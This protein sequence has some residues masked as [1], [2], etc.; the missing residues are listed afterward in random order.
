VWGATAL[1][2]LVADWLK[3]RRFNLLLLGSFAVVALLL[4]G[5]GIYGLISFSVE[6][7]VGEIGIRRAL[8]GRSGSIVGM[9]FRQGARLAGTGIALG[10]LGALLL[11]RF[12]QG[13]LFGVEPAD[14]ATIGLLAAT[15]L[16]VA[17]VSA[18]LPAIRAVRVDPAEA[19][20]NE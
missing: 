2:A 10:V 9:V 13:M 19:L 5:I 15:V 12:I 4:A 7:R 1:D 20:R 11:T 16:L 6:Q 8:G 18:L 3:E 17:G 14:P